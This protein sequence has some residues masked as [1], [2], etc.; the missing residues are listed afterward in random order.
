[1]PGTN[2]LAYFEKSISDG[3][4]K[5]NNID[6]RTKARKWRQ[7]PEPKFANTI[8]SEFVIII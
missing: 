7:R 6:N 4:K 8:S 5:F 3:E 2:T 1:M